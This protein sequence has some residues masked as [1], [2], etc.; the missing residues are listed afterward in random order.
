VGRAKGTGRP[1]RS[2]AAGARSKA[3]FRKNFACSSPTPN[4]TQAALALLDD[5]GRVALGRHQTVRGGFVATN[6]ARRARG[7]IPSERQ[8]QASV[9]AHLELRATA[10]CFWFAVP[11]G[12]WRSRVTGAILKGQGVVAGITDL[13]L[14]CRGQA[15]GL[16]IKKDD[17]RTSP[18]QRETQC[19]M[20]EA[21]AI[22]STTYGVD[23]AISM[24]AAWGLLRGP[25]S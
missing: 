23:E 21:G 12:E 1:Q 6:P 3:I 24:L 8:I 2:V 16:E 7:L 18:V 9:L 10:N 11:N 4:T 13:I 5:A 15:Y 14:I 19:R 22:V 17:G 25:S 20:C